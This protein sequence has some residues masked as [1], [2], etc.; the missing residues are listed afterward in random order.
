MSEF[1]YRYNFCE[2]LVA[3]TIN[4]AYR[5]LNNRNLAKNLDG[6]YKQNSVR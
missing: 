5:I 4:N 3:F 1:K 2:K 6:A